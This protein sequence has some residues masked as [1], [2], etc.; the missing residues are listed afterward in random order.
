MLKL[1]FG[2]VWCLSTIKPGG[3][4]HLSIRDII[5]EWSSGMQILYK[6]TFKWAG[7][8]SGPFLNLQYISSQSAGE[9]A[10]PYVCQSCFYLGEILFSL[11]RTWSTFCCGASTL[12]DDFTN[13]RIRFIC[14]LTKSIPCRE[15]NASDSK[16]S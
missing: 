11:P 6:Y 16:G 9:F 7:S 4:L 3:K 1:G 14:A 10:S 2:G 15:A 13:L 12:F 5:A 8:Q